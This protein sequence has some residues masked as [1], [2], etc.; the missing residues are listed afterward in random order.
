[1]NVTKTTIIMILAIAMASFVSV[2]GRLREVDEG[3][4]IEGGV[5]RK[6]TF[7]MTRRKRREI[8][9][10]RKQ[11]A[12]N[13]A[14]MKVEE[15]KANLKKCCKNACDGEFS[16]PP[17]DWNGMDACVAAGVKVK[18]YANK[19]TRIFFCCPCPEGGCGFS[20]GGML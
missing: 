3:G 5:S 14:K 8:N 15:M 19:F 12:E 9:K 1:M 4:V 11:K 17:A 20:G 7:Y 18:Y 16:E 13:A 6:M 2:E 10:A